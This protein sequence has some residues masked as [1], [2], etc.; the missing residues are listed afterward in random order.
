MAWRWMFGVTAIPS[1]L[2]LAG[3]FFVPESPR[4]LAKSGGYDQAR[5]ILEKV[6]GGAYAADALAEI[7]ATLQQGAPRVDFRNLW[8][9]RLLPILFLGI[10]LAVF[11]QWCGINV[12]FNYATVIF[13][14]AGYPV[15]TSC[16][17]SPLPA[18]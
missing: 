3:T 17:R 16:G 6:G 4:W 11:Q 10:A 14:A 8:D 13:K 18:P 2:F 9:R 5:A 7:R 15:Q 1:L 12:L